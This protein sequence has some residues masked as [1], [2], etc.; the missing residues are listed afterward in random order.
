MSFTGELEHLPI[1]DILQLLHATRKSGI[2]RLAGRKG[3]SQL[4]LKDGYIV[5][6]NHLNSSV[7][8]GK[9]LVDLDIISSE[10]LNLA[11]QVQLRAGNDRK[12]LIV[13]LIEMEAVR[14]EDAYKGLERLIELTLVEILTWKKGTFT[15]E[16]C[17]ATVS[18]T[19]R[20]YPERITSEVSVDTQGILM[21]TLRVF[22]EKMRDG[23]LADKDVPEEEEPAITGELEHLP[24]VDILQLLHATRKS[25][26]LRFASRKGESQL[27]LKDGCIV[28]A[29]HLNSSVRI[30]KILVDLGIIT[31]ET[32]S[33]ALQVQRQAGKDRKPLIVTLIEMG[34][35]SEEDACTGL[36]QLIE[37]TVVEILTWKKGTFTLETS[38]AADSDSLRFYPERISREVRVDT[39]GIL[40]DS[41][42][43]FDEKMHEGELNDEDSPGDTP[44][45]LLEE[46]EETEFDRLMADIGGP[47]TEPEDWGH[48]PAPVQGHEAEE[49]APS[50]SMQE[51]EQLADFLGGL[52]AASDTA[53]E[54]SSFVIFFSPDPLIGHAVTTVCRPVGIPVSVAYTEDELDQMLDWAAAGDK[55]PFLVIDAPLQ[56]DDGFFPEQIFSLR[57]RLRRRHP[58]I[59]IIQLAEPGQEAF[60]LQSYAAGVHAVIPRPSL[61][62]R[63][64]AYVTDTIRFL[65]AFQSYLSAMASGR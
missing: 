43:I 63:R 14:E 58:G 31:A 27:V 65:M 55:L 40:M 45:I 30:G 41:L 46:P 48:D 59:S 6:A 49:V 56:D 8:I 35:V 19:Y 39:Q 38:P 62:D 53:A 47:F 11:L 16:A 44:A 3:E 33:Q 18:D 29:N 36:E 17:P 57:E 50:L 26:V 51:L 32:L 1:V 2:L 52:P 9:I 28:S 4:V 25:G 24:I 60:A 21:D 37:L 5:S 10:T 23:E 22:D 54:P 12:P 64:E 42:R 7:R 13:T 61:H 20:F 15:L 34:V